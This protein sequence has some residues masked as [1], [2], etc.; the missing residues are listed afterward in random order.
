M[1]RRRYS[2]PNYPQLVTFL[3]KLNLNPLQSLN[4]GL[5]SSEN[6]EEP[7][8]YNI[9]TFDGPPDEGFHEEWPPFRPSDLMEF[10]SSDQ[11]TGEASLWLRIL[12]H[13]DRLAFIKEWLLR[14]PTSSVA[15]IAKYIYPRLHKDF[16]RVPT[17]PFL[18]TNAHRR[19][20]RM[21]S[22]MKFFRT[23]TLQTC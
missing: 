8:S 16:I 3:N 19:I 23:L 4:S 22:D 9:T 1:G 5:M 2:P 20:F 6:L 12:E 21:N 15:D 10:M 11:S 14:L 7:S 13:T 17:R 18:I